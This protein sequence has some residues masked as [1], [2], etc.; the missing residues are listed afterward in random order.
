MLGTPLPSRGSYAKGA[1]DPHQAPRRRGVREGTGFGQHSSLPR[2][3][4]DL[5][6]KIACPIR[7]KKYRILNTCSYKGGNMY[8]LC[9]TQMGWYSHNCPS[10]LAVLARKA[11]I[12]STRM[13]EPRA[14]RIRCSP[15]EEELALALAP[16]LPSPTCFV[17]RELVT[18]QK[19]QQKPRCDTLSILKH[20]GMFRVL[21]Q[22][23]PNLS[24]SHNY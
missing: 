14:K 7:T 6:I 2:G 11:R 23:A 1:Y 18:P 9:M 19:G 24:F 8:V 4:C 15:D 21:R 13:E 17:Y 5:A 20:S 16:H 3:P 22:H 12:E 10:L